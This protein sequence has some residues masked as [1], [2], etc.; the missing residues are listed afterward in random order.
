MGTFVHVRYE[1][2]VIPDANFDKLRPI[3]NEGWANLSRLT[4]PGELAKEVSYL[5]DFAHDITLTDDGISLA[6]AQYDDSTS[7][8]HADALVRLLEV[9][10]PGAICYRVD[11][12]GTEL[13]A[14]RMNDDG[15]ISH[16]SGTV[17]YAG[18]NEHELVLVA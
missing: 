16:H 8:G 11:S 3:L 6:D 4:P 1:N 14:N 7:Q 9:C 17:L 15:T 5:F 2:A 10:A 12:S 13:W 18:L